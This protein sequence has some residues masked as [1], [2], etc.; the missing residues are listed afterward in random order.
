MK[1][2][3]NSSIIFICLI[4][5]SCATLKTSDKTQIIEM[6]N[7]L[8]EHDNI[9]I[10]QPIVLSGKIDIELMSHLRDSLFDAYINKY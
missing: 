9:A 3:L 4:V 5:S 10:I 6:K 8:S 2:I 1:I 7:E